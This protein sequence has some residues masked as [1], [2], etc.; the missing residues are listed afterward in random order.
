MIEAGLQPYDVQAPQAV[1]EAA[2]GI[3]TDWRGGPAQH[4]GRIIAA[5]DPA[6]HAAAIEYLSR[7][8]G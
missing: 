5:G 8:G 1:V 6:L 3:V 2:G 4:G 7:S